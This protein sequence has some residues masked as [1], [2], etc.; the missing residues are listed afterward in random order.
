MDFLFFSSLVRKHYLCID[1][2]AMEIFFK[3]LSSTFYSNYYLKHFSSPKLSSKVDVEAKKCVAEVAAYFICSY[4]ALRKIM[5]VRKASWLPAGNMGVNYHPT[6]FQ[7]PFPLSCLSESHIFIPIQP[8]GP[9]GKCNIMS[10]ISFEMHFTYCIPSLPLIKWTGLY[11][12]FSVKLTILTSQSFKVPH[13][14]FLL[15]LFALSKYQHLQN[16]WLLVSAC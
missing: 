5:A 3:N 7:P 16:I 13:P 1:I 2:F 12:G 8:P 9:L 14:L 10:N 11:F 6:Y 15:F 4:L